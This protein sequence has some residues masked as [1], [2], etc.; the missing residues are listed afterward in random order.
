[1]LIFVFRA[2]YISSACM[3]QQTLAFARSFAC[4]LLCSV[5][6]ALVHFCPPYL[7]GDAH[8]TIFLS[9]CLNL[10]S[11]LPDLYLLNCSSC[12]PDKDPQTAD[13]IMGKS[14]GKNGVDAELSWTESVVGSIFSS[15]Q[16]AAN[17]KVLTKS[18]AIFHAPTFQK[19]QSIALI[20]NEHD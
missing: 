20:S 13:V 6:P 15:L 16:L 18:S 11:A 4:G 17:I 14:N 9:P 19:Q 1:M 5:C 2:A 12:L 3:Q 10:N 8:T 7:S